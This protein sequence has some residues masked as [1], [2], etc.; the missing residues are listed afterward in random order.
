MV[1]NAKVSVRIH[2]KT[3]GPMENL[4]LAISCINWSDFEWD[5]PLTILA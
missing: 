5:T 2:I 3:H 1:M 4:L